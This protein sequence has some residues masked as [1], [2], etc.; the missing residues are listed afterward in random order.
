MDPNDATHL[1]LGSER[2]AAILEYSTLSRQILRKWPIPMT[3]LKKNKGLEALLYLP[4]GDGMGYLVAGMQADASLRLFRFPPETDGLELV[5]TLRNPPGSPG[6]DLSALALREKDGMVYFVYDKHLRMVSVDVRGLLKNLGL[7]PVPETRKPVEH[8][9]SH[10]KQF[11]G[12][13]YKLPARGVEAVAFTDEK[14][15][16]VL[17]GVDA[18][19]KHGGKKALWW[20]QGDMFDRCFTEI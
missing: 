4:L 1:Y 10:L 6:S 8:D 15:E 12:G 14:D 9:I 18:P 17:V 19:K 16:K 20:Y 7:I 13:R 11:M 2:P 3:G 5:A